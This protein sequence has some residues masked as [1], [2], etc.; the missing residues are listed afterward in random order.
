MLHLLQC[1]RLWINFVFIFSFHILVLFTSFT[2][3]G[4]AALHER[5]FV[6]L[7]NVGSLR[8]RMMVRRTHVSRRRATI[9]SFAT[10]VR[11]FG[12]TIR[13][14][15]GRAILRAAFWRATIRAA[16]SGEPLFA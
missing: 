12:T 10:I 2:N 14:P 6:S 5:W 4:F 16:L 7:T 1:Q 11:A 8:S 9:R 13:E 15:Y 3:D